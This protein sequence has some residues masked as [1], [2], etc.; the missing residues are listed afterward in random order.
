MHFNLFLIYKH[1]QT[2]CKSGYVLLP[3]T[4]FLVQNF[5]Y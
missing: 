2:I 4:A 1:S 5:K 3:L